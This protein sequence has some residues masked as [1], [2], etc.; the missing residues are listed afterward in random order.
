MKQ[1]SVV[2]P[3]NLFRTVVF[4]SVLSVFMACSKDQTAEITSSGKTLGFEIQTSNDWR[5]LSQSRSV[6]EHP[7]KT[8]GVFALQGEDPDD[9]LFLHV[10]LSDNLS[11]TK[12][13]EGSLKT[14]GNLVGEDDFYESF[15][16]FAYTYMGQWGDEGMQKYIDNVEVT[17]ASGWTTSYLWPGVGYKVRFL[18]YAPLP[19]SLENESQLNVIEKSNDFPSFEYTPSVEPSSQRDLLIAATGEL[20]SA[21]SDL[22]SLTFD[23]VLTGITFSTN[24]ML[25]GQ[26][27]SVSLKG[28]YGTATYDVATKSWS[29]YENVGN[30]SYESTADVTG[31]PDQPLFSSEE[32][33]FFQIPQQLPQGAQLE[34]H[35]VDDLSGTERILTADLSGTEWPVGKIVNYKISTS[36][37]DIE[38][39]FVITQPGDFNYRGGTG[40]YAV[41]S[42][43]SVTRE[44]DEPKTV[45]VSWTAEFVEDDGNGGYTAI[46]RPDWLSDFPLN[47]QGAITSTEYGFSVPKQNSTAYNPHDEALRT[48]AEVTPDEFGYYD[49]STQGKTQPQST[50]N[51]YVVNAPGVYK[52]PLFYGNSMKNGRDNELAYKN[53]TSYIDTPIQAKYIYY[54]NDY[55]QVPESNIGDVVLIWQDAENLITD[56][57]FP[58]GTGGAEDRTWLAFRVN[59]ETIKQGNAL[60]ALR[61]VSGRIMWSWHI[62]VTD[63]KLGEDDLTVTAANGTQYKIMPINVGWCYE[64]T[65]S[66]APREV[67]V[68]FTQSQSNVSTVITI[69]QVAGTAYKGNNPY[70]Q[71]GRKDPFLPAVSL[72]GASA[73]K[74]C[75]FANNY[76]FSDNATSVSVGQAIQHPSTFYHEVFP[77]TD[78]FFVKWCNSL[79]TDVWGASGIT[80][81]IVYGQPSKTIYDPAP[82]GYQV[83]P[84]GIFTGIIYAPGATSDNMYINWSD[85]SSLFAKV[86]TPYVYDNLAYSIEDN[87]G[88]I[89]YCSKM[90]GE[91]NYDPSAG[92]IHLPLAGYRTFSSGEAIELGRLG[93]YWSAIPYTESSIAPSVDDS[94]ASSMGFSIGSSYVRPA[95]LN[96]TIAFGFPIRAVREIN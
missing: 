47:G 40:S 68:R 46:E 38:P 55:N 79:P 83:P 2:N 61:D 93:Y 37:I 13:A 6:G 66:Y 88:W 26:V 71:F 31:A 67:K 36:S 96:N 23:H 58:K 76:G 60:V 21:T 90:S 33:V 86:H 17:K 14:R 89:F 53:R 49:L 65:E 48:A 82:A 29:N 51:C 57:H 56:V 1:L 72:D 7:L 45:P 34:I 12:T 62:W 63:Y 16:V 80:H 69:K 42:Y 44:G 35:Y 85:N 95:D 43:V 15:G 18:A 52:L 8:V 41:T 30:V 78:D 25:P 19:A 94:Y 32:V 50:A 39:T 54:G 59:R 9:T 74:P 20:S 70:Y 77:S 22:V 10:A 28:V 73:D 27:S 75:Y 64:D 92:T 4:A 11:S 91:G 5:P 24:N 81:D 84:S 87:Y 3:F